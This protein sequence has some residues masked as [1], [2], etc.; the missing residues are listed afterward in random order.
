M[1]SAAVE[2][3]PT[4]ALA[5]DVPEVES[6][7]AER[8]Y[9]FNAKA[10]GSFDGLAF[11]ATQRDST[12]AILAGISGHTWAGCCYIAYLW[13][14]ESQR[15][16]GLGTALMAAAEDHAMRMHC[17]VMFVATHS[18]QAPGFYE[19]LGYVRQSLIADHPVG[20]CSMTLAKRLLPQDARLRL[21]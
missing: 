1:K 2:H 16:K 6:F 13:V 14:D 21:P 15:G 7:L 4:I 3:G 17:A 18:F 8:I 5:G 10:T 11:S 9:E 12:G 20:H 19:R